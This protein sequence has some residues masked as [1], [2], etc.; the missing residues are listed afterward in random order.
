V[1][2]YAIPEKKHEKRGIEFISVYGSSKGWCQFESSTGNKIYVS[3][4]EPKWSFF[5]KN[6]KQFFVHFNLEGSPS[7]KRKKKHQILNLNMK[8]S[9]LNVENR[10]PIINWVLHRIY[11]GESFENVGK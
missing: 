7:S 8:I 6:P 11:K 3:F 2:K 5:G 9:I 1:S 10:K 4:S